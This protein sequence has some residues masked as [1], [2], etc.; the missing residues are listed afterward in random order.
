MISP[1]EYFDRI[2]NYK[3]IKCDIRY[4]MP[5]SRRGL[6]IVF[7]GI[8]GA[9]KRTLSKF[10]KDILKSKN[11]KVALFEYPDYNSIWGKI[12]NRYLYNKIDLNI[13][14]EFFV[15]F[16]DILKNQAEIA[17]LLKEGTFIISDRYFS[18]TVAFQCAKGFDYQKARSMINIMD[19]ILPDL[20]IFLQI[21]PVL[22]VE[23]KYK[24][25]GHLDRHEKDANLLKNVNSMYDKILK[26][27]W[28]SKKWI[29]IDGSK[30]LESMKSDIGIIISKLLALLLK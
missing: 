20:T 8:D 4:I 17:K 9:G 3:R 25:K 18:S 12:I 5:T 23:R 26:E 7:E 13:E 11:L 29:E 22:A 10:T 21:P 27:N 19:V 30:D 28:L 15:Y 16:I 2:D 1:P 24:E 14:E 6:F